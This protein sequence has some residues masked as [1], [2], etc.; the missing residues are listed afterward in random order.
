M[1]SSFFHVQSHPF[2]A[3]KKACGIFPSSFE[4][5]DFSDFWNREVWQNL[6]GD[7]SSSRILSTNP[8]NHV[9]TPFIC[10][11]LRSWFGW[12]T[13][14]KFGYLS[15]I[16]YVGNVLRL[17]SGAGR[18]ASAGH[19][20]DQHQRAEKFQCPAITC[21]LSSDQVPLVVWVGFKAS[22]FWY[23]LTLKVNF[24]MSNDIETPI[25]VEQIPSL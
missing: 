11:H 6:P 7:A 12:F 9:S 18:A 23:S 3:K 10:T 1:F 21:Q 22:M 17:A 15:S 19:A 2:L 13:P 16:I 20:A 14:L 4:T 8:T 24:T 25:L 5:D